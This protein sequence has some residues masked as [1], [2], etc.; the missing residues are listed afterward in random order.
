MTAAGYMLLEAIDELLTTLA[1]I[2]EGSRV[3]P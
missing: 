1:V 3:T 2:E